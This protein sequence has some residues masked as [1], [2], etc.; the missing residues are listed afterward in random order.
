MLCVLQEYAKSMQS[1]FLAAIG[2]GREAHR[3]TNLANSLHSPKNLP[4]FL[5]NIYQ[6]TPADLRGAPDYSSEAQSQSPSRASSA[7]SAEVIASMVRYSSQF[8]SS[9]AEN[10]SGSSGNGS[11]ISLNF[12]W[13]MCRLR[14]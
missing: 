2:P 10:S 8:G 14:V 7:S 13:K 4:T 3:D 1:P 11:R 9:S 6:H 5:P 12:R